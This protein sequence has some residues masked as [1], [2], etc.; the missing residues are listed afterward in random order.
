VVKVSS[1][2]A[3]DILKR[4][5]PA[6]RAVLLYGPDLGMV[7]ERAGAVIVQTIGRIDDPFRIAELSGA[8]LRDNTARLK[9]EAAAIAFGGGRRVVRIRDPRD[10]SAGAFEFLM[11]GGP[12]EALVIVEAGDLPKR[13]ALRRLFEGASSALA[14]PCY[15]D[16]GASLDAVISQALKSDGISISFEARA[17]LHSQ[18]GSDRLLARSELE[19]LAVHAGVG[20]TIDVEDVQ[21]MIGDSAD[22][23]L[24]DVIYA[25]L[26]GQQSAL[27]RSLARSY[28]DGVHPVAIVRAASRHLER[29]LDIS[30]RVGQGQ[31]LDDVVS[32]IRPP[33]FFK[34]VAAFKSQ[35]HNWGDRDLKAA[36][37]R[38]LDAEI[39]LKSSGAPAE[40]IC[41]RTLMELTQAARRQ[42]R[43]P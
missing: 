34:R 17:F 42:L 16:E 22:A 19:K 27:D 31:S 20:G 11:K 35:A 32:G 18:L 10:E 43:R 23:S 29:L 7:R 21:A 4:L 14:V 8:M 6:I 39:H 2:R 9:D 12:S 26:S 36:Y 1:A 15:P 37:Q 38:I 28:A 3:D 25:A 40:A 33:I 24:D 30:A 5:D 13:S 41:N